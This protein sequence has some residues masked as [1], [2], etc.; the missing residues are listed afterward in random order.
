M[1][2]TT[3]AM[4]I[5]FIGIAAQTMNSNGSYGKPQI[6]LDYQKLLSIEDITF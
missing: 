4:S 3:T 2:G 5:N 6:S 1:P